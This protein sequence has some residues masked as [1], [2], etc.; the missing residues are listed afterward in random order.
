MRLRLGR[1]VRLAVPVVEHRA[2]PA[3]VGGTSR[4]RARPG[5][6]AGTFR[7]L[8]RTIVGA[9]AAE[10]ATIAETSAAVKN[11]LSPEEIDDAADDQQSPGEATSRVLHRHVSQ[12]W[13]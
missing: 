12:R 6:V 11:A 5:S 7:P 8:H 10:P 2:R 3:E 9:I 1:L 13:I 4:P